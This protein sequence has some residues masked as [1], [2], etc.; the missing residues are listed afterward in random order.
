MTRTIYVGRPSAAEKALYKKLLQAQA[1]TV[2]R[3]KAGISTAELDEFCRGILGAR[4][5][6]QFVHGLGHGLGTQVHEWPSVSKG[7]NI[8]LEE[9]MLI[10]IE[11]GIYKKNVYGIRIED[12]VVVT[13]TSGRV[14]TKSTKT[15][16]PI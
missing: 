2:K 5:N 14:L 3:V 11:P 1:E 10:T 6:K 16:I 7:Q 15:L 4:L 12:D 8:I 9:N 13:K